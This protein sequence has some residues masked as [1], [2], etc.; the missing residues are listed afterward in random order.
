MNKNFI[1]GICNKGF[2][3][4]R[5][6]D[7]H[8]LTHLPQLK[9]FQ[10]L[11]CD[12]S[13]GRKDK[14][15]RHERTHFSEKKW[16]C[17][18]CDAS[19]SRGD[20]LTVHSK[21]HQLNGDQLATHENAMNLSRSI[22]NDAIENYLEQQRLRL[23]QEQLQQVQDDQEMDDDDE[24]QLRIVENEYEMPEVMNGPS[25][26]EN[27]P[28]IINSSPEIMNYP[29]EIVNNP[30]KVM[31]YYQPEAI[32]G[33]PEVP[34][35]E[36]MQGNE[37]TDE[38]SKDIT[39]ILSNNSPVYVNTPDQDPEANSEPEIVQTS[40]VV[41]PEVQENGPEEKIQEELMDLEKTNLIIIPEL[42]ELQDK[43]EILEPLDLSSDAP[44]SQEESSSVCEPEAP[45]D[46][47]IKPFE[48]P[49]H[50]ALNSGMDLMPA[51]LFK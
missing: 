42:L 7:R 34:Q 47:Q 9:P 30:P 32:N 36:L 5:E 43:D 35:D 39:H 26:I 46:L 16:T 21:L 18:V 50:A 17:L 1:C 8:A 45:L 10:C 22:K 48:Q 6:L 23:D 12:K 37:I 3:R 44:L 27:P 31:N 51:H 14:L 25:N 49:T 28:E 4:K 40:T 41:I 24:D 33:L 11:S 29:L 13:F 20:M 15:L 2:S 19:F 38:T